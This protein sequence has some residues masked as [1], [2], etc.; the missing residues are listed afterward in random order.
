M[1]WRHAPEADIHGWWARGEK[2]QKSRRGLPVR[3]A[4]QEP[5]PRHVVPGGPVRRLGEHGGAVPVE[6]GPALLP[7]AAVRSA[8]WQWRQLQ[9]GLPPGVDGPARRLPEQL[10][11]EEVRQQVEGTP[12]AQFLWG[13]H[14]GKRPGWTEWL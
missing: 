8:P 11:G 5:V 2:V 13:G 3:G 12:Q 1:A 6:D 4:L 10:L 7:H 14:G 9:S